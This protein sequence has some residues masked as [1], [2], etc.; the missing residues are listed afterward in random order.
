MALLHSE[1]LTRRTGRF[2]AQ[3]ETREALTDDLFEQ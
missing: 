3:Q 1:Y 2:S